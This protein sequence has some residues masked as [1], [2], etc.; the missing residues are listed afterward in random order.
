MR[1]VAICKDNPVDGLARRKETR[2][3]HLAYLE[4]LGDSIR[5]AGALPPEDGAVALG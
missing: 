3:K 1:Y 2:P 5:E 4:G